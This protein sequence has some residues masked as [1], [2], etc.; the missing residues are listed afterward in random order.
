M[1]FVLQPVENIVKIRLM[2]I[3]F[4][5]SPDENVKFLLELAMGRPTPGKIQAIIASYKTLDHF[6]LGYYKKKK[7]LG[8]IGLQ[9]KGD[10]GIIKHI[11]VLKTHRTQG[12][13]RM[14]ISEAIKQFHLKSI[15]SETDEEAVEFYLKCNFTISPFEGDYRKRFKCK[16]TLPPKNDRKI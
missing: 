14:L 2:K 3:S 1:V 9:V 12:I 7:L 16:L 10:E 6:L 4:I 15:E 11:S 8:L 13:G 5:Y